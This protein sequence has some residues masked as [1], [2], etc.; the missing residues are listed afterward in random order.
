MQIRPATIQDIPVI[1]RMADIAF[2]HTYRDILSSDQM[3][4]MMDWMY[5]EESL[6]MQ[7]SQDGHRYFIAYTEEG[8]PVGY[9]SVSQEEA[10]VYHL[11]KIYVL[12]DCQKSGT[13]KALFDQ[14]LSFVKEVHPKPCRIELN[15]NRA[16]P[17]IGFYRKMGMS[18]LRQGDFPIGH[19]YYMNDYI[20]GIEL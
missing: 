5:A 16:N 3:E 2:R 15:V 19:G 8:I 10:D 9:V 11:Q 1:H 13:G 20:M 4:Y 14:V 7:M 17:A 12:P 18:I 6:M